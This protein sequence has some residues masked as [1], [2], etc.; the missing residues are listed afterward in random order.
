MKKVIESRKMLKKTLL[1]DSPV[2][3]VNNENIPVTPPRQTLLFQSKSETKKPLYRSNQNHPNILSPISPQETTSDSLLKVIGNDV[4]RN[5][6]S[7]QKKEILELIAQN[8]LE[9]SIND[10]FACKVFF[11]KFSLK[12][13]P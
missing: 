12:S 11:F 8:H 10:K 13:N 2:P 1:E 3:K 9:G 4:N 5:V 6:L 7:A